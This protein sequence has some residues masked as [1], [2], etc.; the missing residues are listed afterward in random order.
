MVW[1]SEDAKKTVDHHSRW[2]YLLECYCLRPVEPVGDAE[3][4]VRVW[5]V[6]LRE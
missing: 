3:R 2:T 4:I 6:D 5:L 1:N